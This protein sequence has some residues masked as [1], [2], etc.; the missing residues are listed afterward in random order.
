MINTL[1]KKIII[2]HEFNIGLGILKVFLSFLVI[3]FHYFD[4]NSTSNSL[5]L[6][7]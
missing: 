7:S 6:N 4:L 5:F 3:I 2:K 1:T